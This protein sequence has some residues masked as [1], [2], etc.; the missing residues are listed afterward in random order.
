M[1]SLGKYTN[2]NYEVTIFDDGTKVRE[3]DLDFFAPEFPESFDFKITNQ[4]DMKCA[5][6]HE[7]STPDGKHG[8][9][10]NLS[11]IDQ[12]R[13]YTEIAIGGGNPL[14]HPDLIPFLAKC[15]D[16]KLIP[17]MTVNQH[18]FMFNRVLLKKLVDQKLIYGLGV[19]LATV[20]DDFIESIKQFPNAVIHVIAGMNSVDSLKKLADQNLKILIL[21]YKRFRRGKLLYDAAAQYING[22]IQEWREALPSIVQWFDVV[23]F[24]NLAIEQLDPK[25]LLTQEEYDEFFMG[26]DG[27][28][29]MYVDA[30]AQ[31]FARS[32]TSTE[33]YPIK[34]NI[35][36]MFAIVRQEVKGDFHQHNEF[37]HQ[38]GDKSMP[39]YSPLTNL[40]ERWTDVWLTPTQTATTAVTPTR[41][42]GVKIKQVIFN[43][44][45]TIVFWNDGTKTVV[46]AHNEKFDKEKGLAMAICKKAF[47]N[48][49]N[50]NEVFKQFCTDET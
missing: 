15:R 36:D 17:S 1:K 34:D 18:H 10:M 19:S 38:K 4:C 9:I 29:T 23:S 47:G 6:C 11:F 5:M 14:T 7:D 16:L 49:G 40:L 20:T 42:I 41:T 22:S 28:A 50:F 45:A 13:P 32:S 12:L 2:G 21:G 37:S 24:D 46:K 30:V 31:E 25:R 8:D 27:F 48:K 33:R 26:A 35:D 3:N 43:D 44:P 39:A